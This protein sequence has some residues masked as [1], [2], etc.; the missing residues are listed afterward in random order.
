MTQ[1]SAN[2][3]VSKTR[4]TQLEDARSGRVGHGTL[5]TRHGTTGTAARFIRNAKRV[6]QERLPG[7]SG[8]AHLSRL[9]KSH[10]VGRVALALNFLSL[11]KRN[12]TAPAAHPS[13][14]FSWM[15]WD[16]PPPTRIS[17]DGPSCHRRSD[18]ALRLHCVSNSMTTITPSSQ[19]CRRGRCSHLERKLS[20]SGQLAGAIS[21]PSYLGGV[22]PWEGV[23]V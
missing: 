2:S 14:Q 6:L 5:G 17:D 22:H 8:T 9:A 16:T 19:L 21:Q 10:R 23:P 15:D 12:L 13:F 1:I 18:F 11:S 4:F 3:T 20:T 7:I